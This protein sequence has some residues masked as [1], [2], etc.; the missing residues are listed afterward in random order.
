MDSPG[1]SNA[2]QT[3]LRLQDRIT[4]LE[5]ELSHCHAERSKVEAAAKKF[6]VFSEKVEDF[7]FITFD[8]EGRIVSWSRGAERILGYPE[9]VAL[10]QPA[11]MIFTPEDRENGQAQN[12]LAKASRDG[13]AEDDRWHLR[14]DGTRFWGSGIMTA[15]RDHNGA[16]QGYSKVMRDLTSR[17]LIQERLQ[18]SEE[19]FRL[20]ADNVRD[21]ALVPVDTTGNISGWNPGAERTF[22][23]TER[24]I[25][26][27][28]V[29]LFFTPEDRAKGESEKDLS[30]ALAEGRAE[31]NR[32]MIRRD[33]SRFWARWVTTPMYDSSRTLRGFA[34]VLR[35]ETE[36]Q[37]SEDRLKKSLQEK[38]ILLREIHHRVKNNLHVITGLL[39]L[40]AGQMNDSKLRVVLDELQDRVRAIA[41][42]HETLY[43]SRDLANIDF[44]PYM[45]QLVRDLVV[46]HG[47]D[48]ERIQ[49]RTEADDM[50]LSIEQAL[51]LGLIVNELVS[52]ALKHAFP[53]DRNGVIDVRLRYL[54][55]A[56]EDGQTHER[57]W[58]ELSVYDDGVGID[59]AE[60]IWQKKSMGL[61]I[62]HLLND[63]LHGHLA[64]DQSHSTRF[65][66][67]FP[68]EQF[69]FAEGERSNRTAA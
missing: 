36:R 46:F 59:N 13:C 62:V 41:G 57:R 11:S 9:R 8:P 10:G 47:I 45:Q 39:S 56:L 20:F 63:Q 43:G 18:E 31:D 51:P 44:G 6:H 48:R 67:Q 24:E 12:E 37:Q 1:V 68:L 65:S 27:R 26:G 23:Y 14:Q 69:E 15:H 64:L 40:Q 60:E 21:Y 38:E 66:V 17:K 32:W 53:G 2:L 58:S 19:R 5:Q 25:L 42:L 54:T 7:A 4:R 30:R 55:C 33:G 49:V 22:G 3:P 52:N 34:K 29:N 35:D 16:L 61:R 50:V 28:P